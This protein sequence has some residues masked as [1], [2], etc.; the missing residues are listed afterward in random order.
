MNIYKNTIVLTVIA[1]FWFLPRA[2]TEGYAQNHFRDRLLKH[3]VDCIFTTFHKSPFPYA[4]LRKDDV[5]VLPRP[6]SW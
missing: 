3:G 4:F 1:I 5:L 2:K 6:K